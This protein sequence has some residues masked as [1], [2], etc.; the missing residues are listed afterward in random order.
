MPVFRLPD[1]SPLNNRIGSTMGSENIPLRIPTGW[2]VRWN[3]FDAQRLPGGEL[4]ISDSQDILWLT[5]LPP[6]NGE[7]EKDKASPWREIHLDMGWYNS[8]F[9]IVLLD[10]D[11]E[12]VAR[13][14]ETDDLEVLVAV[15]ERWLLRAPNGDLG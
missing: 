10:P 1:G 4:D 9:R 12:H 2:S 6:P 14:F 13:S 11:W 8:T 7:Y 3:G 5:K 15:I